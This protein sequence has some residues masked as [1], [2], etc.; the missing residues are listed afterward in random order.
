MSNEDAVLTVEWPGSDFM[1]DVLKSL[2]FDYACSVSGSSFRSLHESVVNYGG[3]RNPEFLT[4]LHEESSVAMGHGY[5]KVEGKPL[6]AMVHGAVGL[7]HAA[8]AIYN[9]YCDR[10]PVYVILG[11]RLNAI[12]RRP[13]VEWYHSVQDAAGMVRDYIKWD[14]LPISLA[15]FAES[16]VRGYKIA[17]TPP[18]A[19]VVLVVDSDLQET[20]ID[21]EA[22]FRI[23]KLTLASPPSRRS[24]RRC[25]GGAMASRRREPSDR[26]RSV[27]A[28]GEWHEVSR[29][30]GRNTASCGH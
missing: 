20:A 22:K 2:G 30:T 6:T 10:V 8:M 5:F 27:G 4:C 13:G 15:H 21:P 1:V 14:D 16:A 26:C 19:P 25:R 9:A 29:R 24:E 17:M 23:P 11:N 7:Q 28:D 3:N 12:E 18:M